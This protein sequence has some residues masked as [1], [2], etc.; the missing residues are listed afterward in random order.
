MT[1]E[2]KLGFIINIA[3]YA[4]C[5][6]IIYF[7]VKFL[8]V[9]L[10]PVILGLIITVS[11]QRPANF[12]SVKTGIKKG[13]CALVLVISIYAVLFFLLAA[14]VYFF[15][16]S[17]ISLSYNSSFTESLSSAYNVFSDLTSKFTE[18]LPETVKNAIF[19]AI[20]NLLGSFTDLAG[21]IA[22]G[23]PMFLTSC[24][25][26]ILASCYIAKDY[27]GFKGG[28][29]DALDKKHQLF[30]NKFSDILKNKVL[31]M[32]LGYLKLMLI[33]FGELSVGLLLLRINNGILLAAVISLLDLL[34][35]IGTGT[36]LIPWSAYN[37]IVGNVFL[38]AGLIILYIVVVLVR[39][40][41]EPRIIGKQIGLH[42]LVT[43]IA[44]F[45]GLKVGGFIGM[46]ATPLIL[47]IIFQL[48]KE[49]LFPKF[50]AK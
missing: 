15:S 14:L 2:T 23:L 41:I 22:S 25:V 36:V 50:T 8:F 37:L 19:D 1:K 30:F 7:S 32:L 5:A 21:Q 20:S 47:I 48:Y 42:P 31:K 4:S 18:F 27:D 26:T 49:N 43:V 44:V 16:S 10:F 12:L 9:Y 17:I 38:G 34:P 28:F 29:F 33:T 3:F 46:V 11:V 45:V 13:S 40:V 24:I 6:F 35:I 39:Y